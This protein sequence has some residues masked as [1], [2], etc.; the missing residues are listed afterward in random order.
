MSE[1]VKLEQPEINMVMIL[2]SSVVQAQ[3]ELKARDDALAK[4]IELLEKKYNAKF[5]RTTGT[6]VKDS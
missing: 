3:T 4:A 5:D 2:N 1:N 6:F